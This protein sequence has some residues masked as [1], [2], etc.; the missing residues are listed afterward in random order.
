MAN[1]R[2]KFYSTTDLASG[3]SLRCA[4]TVLDN[5]D[6]NKEL[7]DINDAIELFNIKKYIDANC[8]LTDW[9]EDR[10]IKYRNFAK[11]EIPRAI[12][13]FLSK[14]SDDNVLEL[15]NGLDILYDEDF[16]E[17]IVKYKRYEHIG[18]EKLKVILENGDISLHNI[19]RQKEL[20]TH[21][22]DEI[23][24]VIMRSPENAILLI[25]QHL[26][27]HDERWRTLYFPKALGGD[28][29]E[30]L[31][32]EYIEYENAHPNIIE[33]ISRSQSSQELP[34]SD[35]TIYKAQKRYQKEINAFFEEH[36]GVEMPIEV[37]FDNETEYAQIESKGHGLCAR[38]GL[39]W[40]RENL[41]YPTILNNFIYLFGY[42]DLQYRWI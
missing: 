14:I 16:C 2:V 4:E 31:I 18:K 29:K 24:E 26:E 23:T 3:Y 5:I 12:G 6:F 27:K 40:I 19:L 10:R 7:I 8:Y 13:R 15:I 20:V 37:V 9:D 28:K 36:T 35:L 30:S 25:E 11:V 41:D 42:T 22:E 33:L 21:F 38:Y 32:Q 39:R 17:I 1:T 34:L